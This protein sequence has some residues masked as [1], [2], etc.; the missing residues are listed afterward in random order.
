[1]TNKYVP[2]GINRME[3]FAIHRTLEEIKKCALQGNKT[4]Q[5]IDAALEEALTIGT[6]FQTP[7]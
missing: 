7:D 1:M 5:I 3:A 4:G 6:S 2:E